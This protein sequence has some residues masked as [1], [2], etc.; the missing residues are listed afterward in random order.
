MAHVGDELRLVL[1]RDL[2]VINRFGEFARPCLHLIEQARV[3]DCDYGLVRK[4]ID[5]LDLAFDE[6]AHFAA[7]HEDHP[8]RFARVNER[9]S[10]RGAMTVLEC[11]LLALGVFMPFGQ[12]VR[13]LNRPSV[14]Y[15]ARCNGP[16]LKRYRK[17]S[18]RW[19]GYLPMVRDEAQTIA[20]H[21]E[22]R[23]V[24]RVAQARCGFDQ[25]IEYFLHVEGRPADDL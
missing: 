17:L 9:H 24:L 10:E 18:N 22:N 16:T 14:H 7:P 12:H 25:R 1:A 8:N 11:P 23:N 19:G 5:Q 6:R 15:S 20:K 21:L 3:L 4:G 13:D 2:K